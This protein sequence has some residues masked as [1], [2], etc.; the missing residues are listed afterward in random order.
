MAV[1]EVAV[2]EPL[3]AAV[4]MVAVMEAMVSP[5][6]TATKVRAAPRSA[7]AVG[8][9][10]PHPAANIA[11]TLRPDASPSRPLDGRIRRVGLHRG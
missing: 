2:P 6:V 1:E 10:S 7:P 8:G 5:L 9:R 4:V 3:V 11:P